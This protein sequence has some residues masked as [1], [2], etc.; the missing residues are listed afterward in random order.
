[1]RRE[2]P[3]IARMTRTNARDSEGLAAL[4]R[5][6]KATFTAAS[7]SV[8]GDGFAVADGGEEGEDAHVDV[9]LDGADGAIAVG[10]VEHGGVEAA[11]AV[12]ALGDVAGDAAAGVVV[13]EEGGALV[14]GPGEGVEVEG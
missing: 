14:I 11:P 5:E 9:D 6:R 2:E 12:F 4:S 1:M 13:G 3:R 8:F 10:E 7:R